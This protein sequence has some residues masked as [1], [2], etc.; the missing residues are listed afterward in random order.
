MT[1]LPTI[2]ELIGSYDHIPQNKLLAWWKSKGIKWN[3]QI[4]N[5]SVHLFLLEVKKVW[6]GDLVS[7][8]ELIEKIP[9]LS[10]KDLNELIDEIETLRMEIETHFQQQPEEIRHFTETQQFD[11][12]KLIYF[13]NAPPEKRAGSAKLLKA[14]DKREK[15]AIEFLKSNR[16]NEAA[17]FFEQAQ[18]LYEG[19]F[20]KDRIEFDP[21]RARTAIGLGNALD[22]T[23]DHEGAIRNY[24]QAQALYEGS[25]CKGRIAFDPDRA[26]TVVNLGTALDS[27]GDY[28]GAIRSCKQAQALYEGGFCKGQIIEFEHFYA[29]LAMNLGV[30]LGSMG[31]YEGAIRSLKQ[32][33]ALYEGDFCKDR[34]EL[35][36]D[37]AITAMNLG[38]A[39][40]LKGDY[41]GA[42]ESY[43]QAKA[44]YE[45]DFCKGRIK[46]D[47]DSAGIAVNLG[48]TLG[49]I[50]EY[51]GAIKSFEQAQ[52]LYEGETV[53]HWLPLNHIRCSLYANTSHLLNKMDKPLVWAR[54]KSEL[55][56]RLLELA[57]DRESATEG[58]APTWEKMRRNFAVFHAN[59]LSFVI[60]QQQYEEIPRILFCIQGRELASEVLDELEEVEEHPLPDQVKAYLKLRQ[61]LRKMVQRKKGSSAGITDPFGPGARSLDQR[62]Q[63]KE[64]EAEKEA[65]AEYNQL[66][67]KMVAARHKAS[68]LPGYEFLELPYDTFTLES[69]QA[70]QD[71]HS[72]QKLLL[73]I[74][75]EEVQG[76]LIIKKQGSPKWIPLNGMDELVKQTELL[77]GDRYSYYGKYRRN[78]HDERRGKKDIPVM[79]AAERSRFWPDMI[80]KL[81]EKFWSTIEQH[82]GEEN[83]LVILPQGSLKQLPV[84]AGKPEEVTTVFY[85]GLI[86]Y[87]LQTGLIKR[88]EQESVQSTYY[89]AALLYYDHRHN[90]KTFLPGVEKEVEAIRAVHQQHNS[91]CESLEYP[92]PFPDDPLEIELLTG[93]GHGGDD[94]HMPFSTAMEVS[95]DQFFGYQ[96]I[97]SGRAK[98]QHA[99]FNTCLIAMN[100]DDSRGNPMGLSSAFLRK[101]ARSVTG[102]LY[103]ISDLFASCFG[104]IFHKHWLESRTKDLKTV[105]C[106]TRKEFMESALDLLKQNWLPKLKREVA[107]YTTVREKTQAQLTEAFELDKDGA[108]QIS[109]LIEHYEGPEEELPA[110]VINTLTELKS[111][112]LNGDDPPLMAIG[113]ILYGI[114]T[115][116]R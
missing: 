15:T 18:A 92:A 4:Q 114:R 77:S 108:A 101:G 24:K 42:I 60:D 8:I 37:R 36:P 99:F 65:I 19:D 82:I 91:L 22:S 43:E 61:Q 13:F 17:I 80:R 28:E 20:C 23:G 72:H 88:N 7:K 9:Y 32:A 75:Y 62:R 71:F 113:T 2:E 25:F 16:H 83:E 45:G 73:M 96:D 102:F 86:Y 50:G 47:P 103:P 52:K 78:T 44:I 21:D 69:I 67:N 98:V 39:L 105:L 70:I 76:V 63:S 3:D 54:Q 27:T 64:L 109:R 40:G 84:L 1:E 116:G 12:E 94:P 11:H 66:H 87:A 5:A 95:R 56:I 6:G 93:I 97:L 26:G 100:R 41:E 34:I 29:L 112:G 48:L 85:P 111:A 104:P 53:D 68:K 107:N 33:Q 35:D 59:W 58:T 14:I 89:P 81:R 55:L 31:D 46:F 115:Y 110:L 57:P 49:S 79:S 106:C 74:H 51:E 90:P 10:Q 30:I 38:N